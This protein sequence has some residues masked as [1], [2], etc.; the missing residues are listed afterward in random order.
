MLVKNIAIYIAKAIILG[1]FMA[2]IFLLL[3]ANSG[4][5]LDFNQWGKHGDTPLSFA[6][7]VRQAAPA[8]VNIYNIN[9]VPSR[10]NGINA[11]TSRQTL[12]GL[13]SGV[14]MNKKGYILTNYHVIK[15]ADEIYAV[16]QDGRQ[17]NAEII[18]MDPE[19]D[20]AVLRINATELPSASVDLH[21]I[22]QVGDIALAIGNPYNI[23]Q[24]ITQG[25][26]SATGRNGLSS[27]FQ[28]FL[29]TD[30]AINA[31]NSGGA[32]IDTKGN[33]IGINTAAFQVAGENGHGI[34]FAI[35]IRLAYSI[36]EKL[37]ENGRVIRGAIGFGGDAVNAKAVQILKLPSF[38]GVLVTQIDDNSPAEKA[39]LQKYDVITQFNGHDIPAGMN[40]L[41]S[42]KDFIAESKPGS[43]AKITLIRNGQTLTITT[44]I[45][46]KQQPVGE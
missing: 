20:L 16:L 45:I 35:P 2:V 27:N 22:A 18:G 19:T 42:L 34:N 31:G 6:P 29:Q 41:W 32:L 24:T 46:E 13:G 26:I 10:S 25:I 11:L 37:I 8:V 9:F 36:M 30:A 21:H 43:Q 17:F 40:G 7:A 12:Q 28:D 23:G 1:L 5:L 44:D 38:N 4:K 15:K 39:G 14:I 3:N 33:L